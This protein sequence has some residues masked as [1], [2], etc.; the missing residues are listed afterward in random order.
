MNVG[1]VGPGKGI[2][3]IPAYNEEETIAEVVRGLVAENLGVDILVVDDGSSDGTGRILRGLPVTVVTHP[4]NLG[5]GAAVQT[6]MFYAVR[7][8]YD[9]LA[10]MDADGQHVPSQ[11]R[12]LLDEL[13]KGS[14]M[15]IG[16]R[17]AGDTDVYK[18]PFFRRAGIRFFSFL[19][20]ALGGIDIRDVTSG[21]QAMRR[22]VFEFLSR[23]YPVDSPDAEV[24]VMLGRKRFK[25]T[26]VAASVRERQG[27]KSMYS[28][29]GTAMYYPFKSVLSSFIVLLR[30]LREK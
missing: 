19:A 22:S 7:E 18:V 21:F 14:D 6:G 10:L 25:V 24:I 20:H 2:V 9:Y 17:F 1:K 8:G 3:V 16:S 27:G 12:L 13:G 11:V 30:L 5:Y 29:L 15:V 28:N 26:E 23:E 4:V